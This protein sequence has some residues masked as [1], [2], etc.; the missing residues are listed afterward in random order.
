MEVPRENQPGSMISRYTLLLKV[1]IMT[2]HFL[3]SSVMQCTPVSFSLL[4]D[5]LDG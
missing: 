1:H 3:L 2:P 4:V 5:A